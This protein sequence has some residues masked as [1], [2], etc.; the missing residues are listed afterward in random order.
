MEQK[1]EIW[2]DVVGYEGLYQVSN[3]GNV[4]SLNFNRSGQ[5]KLL[6]LSVNK[7]YTYPQVKLYKNEV[8]K[9]LKVHRILAQAFIPNPLNLPYINHINAIRTDNRLE[10]LEWITHAEN[11]QHAFNIGTKSFTELTRA[12][13]IK[14]NSKKV[15]NIKTNQLYDSIKIASEENNMSV[16][17]LSSRLTG[18]VV[19]DT[20]L[21][22]L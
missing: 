19:N 4:K 10:N 11:I 6:K 15:I 8:K 2:K 17:R 9:C 7:F 18:R 5:E 14:A 22:Y 13:V 12:A 21:R 20:N 1:I 16:S 3:L